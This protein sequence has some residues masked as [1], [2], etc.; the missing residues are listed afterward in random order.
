LK[1]HKIKTQKSLSSSA[2]LEGPAGKNQGIDRFDFFNHF[3]GRQE[4][5]N[6]NW[7]GLPLCVSERAWWLVVMVGWLVVMMELVVVGGG[8]KKRF[9]SK[10]SWVRVRRNQ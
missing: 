2:G 10:V 3:G 8:K 5:R 9:G 6:V 1:D 7:I 4:L